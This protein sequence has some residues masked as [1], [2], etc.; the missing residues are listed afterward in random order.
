M[1]ESRLRAPLYIVDAFA[2]RPF[3]GNP[4]AVVPLERYPSDRL[5]QAIAGENNLSETAFLVPDGD[6]FRIRWFTPTEEVP[7]CGHATLASAAV[8]LEDLRPNRDEVEFRSASGP[9][10][11]RRDGDNYEMDFPSRPG[12]R[13]EPPPALVRALGAVPLEV[14]ED[15][16]NYLA[17]FDRAEVVRTLRPDL[18]AVASL[19]RAGIIVSAPA[20]PPYDFVS[21]YFAPARGVPEDPVTGSA[22]CMLVP[23]WAARLGRP[24]LRAFQASSRGGEV[25]GIDRGPRVVLRGRAFRYAA[26]TLDVAL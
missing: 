26:G 22:H 17:V 5:L 13:V 6:E 7:L 18:G 23:Y 12:A 19:D 20:E 16:V 4:A 15:P 1:P 21:R 24:R 2:L 14:Q 8:V 11:V 10:R 9:L 3:T 25:E